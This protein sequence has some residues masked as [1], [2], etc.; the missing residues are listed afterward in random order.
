MSIARAAGEWH[1]GLESLDATRLCQEN[2]LYADAISRAYYAVMHAAKALLELQD[3]T[4]ESH[5][6]VRNLF[7][8][9]V[10]ISGLVERHW[11]GEIRE[12]SELRMIADYNVEAVFTEPDGRS[13]YERAEA[14]LDRMRPILAVAV[15][16]PEPE[17]PPD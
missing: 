12:L 17:A 4:A 10:V 1:R 5:E 15:S 11:G 16:P 9:N 6:G 2:G 8:Y 7:G 13:A 14:F 3:I